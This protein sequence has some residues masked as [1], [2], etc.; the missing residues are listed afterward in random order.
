MTAKREYRLSPQRL[1]DLI[2]N[3]QVFYRCPSC[4]A[5]Y[6]NDDIRFLGR[7]EKHCFMQLN[8]SKCS[9]PVLATVLMPVHQST[10]RGK[11]KPQKKKPQLGH[12]ASRRERSAFQEQ[13]AITAYEIADFY[14]FLHSL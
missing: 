3:L 8:C 1:Q 11:Q 5:D 4:S 12:D 2:K 7:V 9:L 14:A 10:A 6:L 13:G